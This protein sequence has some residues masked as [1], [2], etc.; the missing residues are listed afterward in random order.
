MGNPLGKM[1]ETVERTRTSYD[2]VA[3]EYAERFRDEMDRKEFDRR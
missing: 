3:R 2:S 1:S